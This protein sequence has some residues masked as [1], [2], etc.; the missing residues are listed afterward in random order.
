MP[1]YRHVESSHTLKSLFF[2]E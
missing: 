1:P 2:S